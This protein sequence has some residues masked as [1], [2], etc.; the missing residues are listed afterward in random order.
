M[1][2]FVCGFVVVVYMLC[3]WTSQN[4]TITSLRFRRK[5]QNPFKRNQVIELINYEVHMLTNYI[6]LD[7]LFFVY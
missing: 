3:R 6:F 2:Y 7:P 5:E 4:L 1:I